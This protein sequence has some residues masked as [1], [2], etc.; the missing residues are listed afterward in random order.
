[1]KFTVLVAALLF[2]SAYTQNGYV[3]GGSGSAILP[4]N[5]GGS[6]NGSGS[7]SGS[8]TISVTIPS[9]PKADILKVTTASST[10]FD[11]TNQNIANTIN[12][13]KNQLSTPVRSV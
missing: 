5:I 10:N 1:M 11:T 13:A 7:G 9:F 4:T 2:G 6:D 8:G 3:A 12:G